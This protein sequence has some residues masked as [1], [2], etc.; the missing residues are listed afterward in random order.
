MDRLVYYNDRIVEA[1]RAAVPATNAGLLYGWGV[2]TT[3]R[4][5]SAE[6]F[7]LDRHWE[8]L[9]RHAQQALIELSI[10]RDDLARAIGDLI[11]ANRVREG[12]GRITLL[13]ADAG[14]WGSPGG[15]EADLLIFTS[16]ERSRSGARTA[17]TI[18][19]YRMTSHGPL[20][21]IKRTA[22]LEN[23][24]ALEEAR[25]RDFSEALMVNERG[26][27]VGAAAANIFWAEAGE[28]FTPS[29]GTGCIAGIT[30][31]FVIEIARRL[32]LS[33]VEGG[34]PVQRLLDATEVFLTSTA[35]GIVSVSSFDLKQYA[36]EQG[37]M[38]RAID[39]EFQ[40]LIRDARIGA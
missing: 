21:G 7:A 3:V 24:L 23:L 10:G 19:P 12:R 1:G 16:S 14:P 17:I 28:L 38:S 6:V 20:A 33:V 30:R 22:M 32:S 27:V 4:V 5:Y 9:A 18:S 15:R 8:R 13:K 34:F 35:R 29:A 25:S 40:K 11:A 26:E 39:R 37:W 2:F 36:P 31:G